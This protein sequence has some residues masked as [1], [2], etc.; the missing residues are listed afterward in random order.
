MSLTIRPRLGLA[1]AIAGAAIVLAAC[2]SAATPTPAAPTAPP[3]AAPTEAPSAAPS[4][5]ASQAPSAAASQAAGAG[6]LALAA[7][8]GTVGPYLTGADGKTLYVYAKDTTPG[9]SVCNGQCAT[10]WPP[11]TVPAG[12]AATA[13]TGVNGTIGTVTR[14][15]GTTQVTYNG[16]PVYYFAGDQAAGTTNGQGVGGVWTVAAP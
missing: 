16:K 11:L 5:A 10:N 3:T 9:K 2:S 1:T 13:G 4:A 8:S 12:A 6:G 7:A 14:D 15:D